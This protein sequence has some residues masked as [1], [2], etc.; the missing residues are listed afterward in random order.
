MASTGRFEDIIK[1][2]RVDT[3]DAFIICFTQLILDTLKDYL[4]EFSGAHVDEA[5]Q[6][7][8]P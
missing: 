7:A 3:T 5:K 4:Q 6:H 1:D 8:L 2:N